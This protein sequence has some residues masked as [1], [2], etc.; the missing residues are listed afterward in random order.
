MY[1]VWENMYRGVLYESEE[2]MY[3][4]YWLLKRMFGIQ[5]W[6]GKSDLTYGFNNNK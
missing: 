3:Q 5:A 1:M 2:N 4:G 6:E